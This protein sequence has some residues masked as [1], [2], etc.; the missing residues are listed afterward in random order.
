MRSILVRS[1]DFGLLFQSLLILLHSIDTN[2]RA[3]AEAYLNQAVEAQYVRM[4]ENVL[5]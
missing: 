3:Q 1:Q 5:L 4:L 2:T